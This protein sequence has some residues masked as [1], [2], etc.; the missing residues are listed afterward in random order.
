MKIF[1]V[2]HG[3]TNYNVLG[4]C[5]DDTS[6]NVHLTELGKQQAE[7]IQ[8]QMKDIFLDLVITSEFP[9]AKETAT[10]IAKNHTVDFKTDPRLNDRKTGQFEDKPATD[11]L[12]SLKNDRFNLKFENGESFLEEKQRVHD[13]LTELHNYN[14]QHILV[15]TH[16]EILQIINGYYNNLSDDE[17]LDTNISNGQVLEII[18]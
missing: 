4:L 13:F 12:N 9:R 5:N 18:I 11:F 14:H 6:K 10:I 7:K 2:R 3:Q 17:M 16:F 1:F 15:V 8:E